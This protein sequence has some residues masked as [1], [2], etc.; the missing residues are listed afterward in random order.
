MPTKVQRPGDLAIKDTAMRRC[1]TL[2][3]MKTMARFYRCDGPCVPISPCVIVKKGR[4]IDLTEA[5]TM[6][7]IAAQTNIPVPRVYC[8][9]VRK[10]STYIVMQ[11]IRGKTLAAAWP[12]L[13]DVEREHVLMQL[14]NI[15]QE[16]RALPAQ[17][18]A[19]QSC[20]GGSLRDSRIPRSKPRFGPFPSILEF[21]HWLREGLQLDQCPTENDDDDDKWTEIKRMMAMQE[22]EFAPPVFTHGDLNPFNILVRDGKIVGV[23]DWEF[24]GWYPH[25]WEYTSAWLGNKTRQAWQN[26]LPKFMDPCPEELG[27]EA[28]RQRWWG[29]F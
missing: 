21:H 13:S 9:F 23:I 18:F 22:G 26:L 5:A 14:R 29:D 19:I 15:I 3:A 17:N 7:F 8:S 28:I 11:R 24:S 2:L 10:R 16:L 20:V 4:S 25:Y 12:G 6:T 27:M 1:F